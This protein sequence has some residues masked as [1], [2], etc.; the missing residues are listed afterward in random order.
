MTIERPYFMN[1]Q[2]WYYHDLNEFKYKLTVKGKALKRVVKSY[3]DFYELLEYEDQ[4]TQT[5]TNK[6]NNK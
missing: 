2:E 1:N 3:N 5:P 4:V 6:D